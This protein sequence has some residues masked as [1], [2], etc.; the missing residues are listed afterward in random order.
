MDNRQAANSI[1][2]SLQQQ[3]PNAMQPGGKV[4]GEGQIGPCTAGYLHHSPSNP[5]PVLSLLTAIYIF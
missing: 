1:T 4:S 2:S 3:V 5:T